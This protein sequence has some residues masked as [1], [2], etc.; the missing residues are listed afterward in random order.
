MNGYF[1]IC[2]KNFAKNTKG[3]DN[4]V[5]KKEQL[6]YLIKIFHMNDIINL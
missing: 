1:H 2:I 3:D 4:Y 5:L 6:S